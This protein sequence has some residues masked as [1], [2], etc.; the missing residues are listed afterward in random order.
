MLS[1]IRRHGDDFMVIVLNFT[2]VP[3]EEYRVGVPALGSYRELFNSNSGYYGGSDV[4]NR[5]GVEADTIPWDGRP[6]SVAMTIPPL[7][8]IVLQYSGA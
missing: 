1:F 2:P 6:C 7:A 5:G 4:G 3:R 8:G